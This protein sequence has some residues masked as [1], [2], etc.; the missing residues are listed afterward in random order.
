MAGPHK[1]YDDEMEMYKKIAAATGDSLEAVCQMQEEERNNL[2]IALNLSEEVDMEKVQEAEASEALKG[3]KRKALQTFMNENPS[4]RKKEDQAKQ[5]PVTF[6][7]RSSRAKSKKQKSKKANLKVSEINKIL[8][9]G[10][11]PE[12]DPDLNIEDGLESEGK[13]EDR[14][15]KGD[16]DESDHRPGVSS[17]SSHTLP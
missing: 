4:K 6:L 5:V 9:S 16:Q 10:T 15:V 13:T 12:T 11:D 3:N 7:T 14:S 8:E 2:R 1:A 17:L